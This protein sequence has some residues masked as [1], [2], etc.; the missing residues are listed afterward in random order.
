MSVLSVFSV[1]FRPEKMIVHIGIL[2]IER[3]SS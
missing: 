1:L 2:S 3:I